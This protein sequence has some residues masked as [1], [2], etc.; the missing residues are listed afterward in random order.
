MAFFYIYNFYFSLFFI[1]L[2]STYALHTRYYDHFLCVLCKILVFTMQMGNLT[3]KFFILLMF[4]FVFYKYD[5]KNT[6]VSI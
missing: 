5:I 4:A 1:I 6:G 2:G 3:E